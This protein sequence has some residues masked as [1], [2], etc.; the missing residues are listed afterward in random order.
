MRVLLAP[1]DIAGQARITAIELEKRGHHA[2][3]FDSYSNYLGYEHEAGQEFALKDLPSSLQEYD[4]FDVFFGQYNAI[5]GRNGLPKNLKVIH[6]FCGSDVRQY[7]IATKSNPFAVVKGKN[8]SEKIR[9]HLK[10]L[11]Q[12]TSHCTIMNEEMRPHVAPFFENVHILPRMIDLDKYKPSYNGHRKVT[13]VHA[14]T[15]S[16]IKGT[17]DIVKAVNQLKGVEDFN[18]WLVAGI[19]HDKAMELYSKADI[20]VCELNLGVYG[21]F[22]LE[23]MA[24]GKVVITRISDEMRG[25]YP[26]DLPIISADPTNIKEVLENALKMTPVQRALFGKRARAYVEKHHSP[27]VVVPKLLDIYESITIPDNTYRPPDTRI[28]SKE[29]PVEFY[30]DMYGSDKYVG[31]GQYGRTY[32]AILDELK[33]IDSPKVLEIGCGLGDFGNVLSKVSSEYYG[34]DFSSIA[35][36]QA[37]E[38]YPVIAEKFSVLDLY[39]LEYFVEDYDTIIACEVFEHIDDLRFVRSVKKGIRFMLTLPHYGAETHL[40]MYESPE[41]IKERFKGLIEF[42]SIKDHYI[43]NGLFRIWVVVGEKI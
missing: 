42:S 5:G 34:T 36:K 15:H 24:L 12:M 1:V 27:D 26:D 7:D 19:R 31:A 38:R 4:V 18:F 11:S 8:R 6:H 39:E 14:S 29:A 41:Q 2:R 13:V 43:L 17:P 28:T 20:V 32:N 30:D 40:R 10:Q 33:K 16:E 37:K 23:A 25:S 3:F 35:I 22:A 21:I 9:L